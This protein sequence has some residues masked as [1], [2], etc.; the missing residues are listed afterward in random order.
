MPSTM[1]D[2]HSVSEPRPIDKNDGSLP[3]WEVDILRDDTVIVDTFLLNKDVLPPRKKK[4]KVVWRLPD[5]AD[6]L[7][8]C[9]ACIHF[10]KRGH[11]YT[12]C[13]ST[14]EIF[15]SYFI[16]GTSIQSDVN[17]SLRLQ[18][19]TVVASWISLRNVRKS[20]SRIRRS[21]ISLHLRVE[22]VLEMGNVS[23]VT[24]TTHLLAVLERREAGVLGP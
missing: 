16:V 4:G 12:Y 21:A 23:G 9:I 24:A 2:R 22:R 14:K 10:T 15:C 19:T 18:Q 11:N 5:K 6:K 20:A 13:N 3:S 7:V 17:L 8:S 1:E